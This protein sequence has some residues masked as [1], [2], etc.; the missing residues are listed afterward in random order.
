M[1]QLPNIQLLTNGKTFPFSG[2]NIFFSPL[3][4]CSSYHLISLYICMHACLYVIIIYRLQWYFLK[5]L[6]FYFFIFN[7]FF[8]SFL[9]LSCLITLGRYCSCFYASPHLHMHPVRLIRLCRMNSGSLHFIKNIYINLKHP[10]QICVMI[11]LSLSLIN[12]LFP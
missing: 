4:N 8:F 1:A 3:K 2:F 10:K 12:F 6:L 11:S 5:L 7:D 9:K